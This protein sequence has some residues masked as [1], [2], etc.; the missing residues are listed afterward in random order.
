[1]WNLSNRRRAGWGEHYTDPELHKSNVLR[2]CGQKSVHTPRQKE[3]VDV[4]SPVWLWYTQSLHKRLVS[5][6]QQPMWQWPQKYIVHYKSF[7]LWGLE[8]ILGVCVGHTGSFDHSG[9]IKLATLTD[10]VC[11]LYLCIEYSKINMELWVLDTYNTI[12]FLSGETKGKLREE[13]CLSR[14]CLE[15]RR[16]GRT[17]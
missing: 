7:V 4:L 1:M 14:H 9:I 13:D 11:Y 3:G 8:Y 12:S 17:G 6:K 10:F 2:S 16:E 15:E 5:P